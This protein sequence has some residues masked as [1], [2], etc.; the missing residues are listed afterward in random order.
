MEFLQ[1]DLEDE[2]G[3]N[4]LTT[5]ILS[6]LGTQMAK[7]INDRGGH[8]DLGT[9]GFVHTGGISDRYQ[10]ELTPKVY[11]FWS[12]LDLL[13]SAVRSKKT[14]GAQ[15]I[16]GDPRDGY[17]YGQTKRIEL[18]VAPEDM[19]EMATDLLKYKD[20]VTGQDVYFKLYY[21]FHSSLLHELRHA[22]D[23]MRTDSKIFQD[24]KGIRFREKY[25]NM[26]KVASDDQ[27][28]SD[29]YHKRFK[30][31]VQQPHE[32]WARASQALHKTRLTKGLG[33]L[34]DEET[35][36]PLR[37]VLK[38]FRVNYNMLVQRVNVW[39]MMSEK[40]RKRLYKMVANAWHKKQEELKSKKSQAKAGAIQEKMNMTVDEQELEDEIEMR[41]RPDE[42]MLPYNDLM[43]ISDVFGLP[44]EDAAM[45]VSNFVIKREKEKYSEAKQ[46]IE[47]YV[48]HLHQHGVRTDVESDESLTKSF[49]EAHGG[50]HTSELGLNF[51]A[52]KNIMHMATK[53]PDQLKLFEAI[54]KQIQKTILRSLTGMA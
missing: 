37:D 22:Y 11:D 16:H 6:A 30:A 39:Q 32:I 28:N 45:A 33:I 34:G 26:G 10:K 53:D 12:K 17:N 4:S 5:G 54:R 27:N 42:H 21:L 29:Y 9:Y 40:S 8:F 24:P 35:M 3:L 7:E 44:E 15:Y 38:D 20:E 49:L 31:Y 13:V 14:G 23:D 19:Q 18:F 50:Y 41:L 1:E 25:G 46:D 36:I 47:E 48:Q 52:L 43:Y 2:K 51:D